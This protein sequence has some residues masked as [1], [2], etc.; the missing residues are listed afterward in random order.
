MR[1]TY[2]NKPIS[3]SMALRKR[4]PPP[5]VQSCF[6]Q[7][8]RYPAFLLKTQKH[9]LQGE[10]GAGTIRS[11]TKFRKNAPPPT[12]C[13]IFSTVLSKIVDPDALTYI[14]YPRVNCLKTIPFSAAH[15]YIA[16][17]WQY[18]SPPGVGF[19][20]RHPEVVPGLRVVKVLS[21][22]PWRHLFP[23]NA[24]LLHGRE[25]WISLASSEI[26]SNLFLRRVVYCSK[27][28]FGVLFLLHN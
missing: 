3:K 17:I 16:H 15:T 21:R 27:H 18:P 1:T 28:S 5:P 24:I 11:A 4:K 9:C 7:M 25:S 20:W 23:W 8:L 10:G 13:A 19:A 14:P 6:L 26:L 22:D 12:K 2:C